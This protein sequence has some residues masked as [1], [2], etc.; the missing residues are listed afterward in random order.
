MTIQTRTGE[1][2]CFIDAMYYGFQW[3]EA[4][5]IT[6]EYSALKRD[7]E[8]VASVQTVKAQP[9]LIGSITI[10]GNWMEV[11]KHIEAAAQDHAEKEFGNSHV[12]KTIMSAI[13]PHI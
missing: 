4:Q 2:K 6:V 5:Y 12:D 11:S 1:F 7:N 9:W 13:A 3:K 8:V 10:R